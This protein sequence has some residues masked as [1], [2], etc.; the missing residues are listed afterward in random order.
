MT[1]EDAT[2]I[3]ERAVKGESLTAIEKYA[4]GQALLE[5]SASDDSILTAGVKE[6]AAKAGHYFLNSAAV[7]AVDDPNLSE[8]QKLAFGKQAL[9]DLYEKREQMGEL[10]YWRSFA[11]LVLGPLRA[12][13]AT[14]LQ[15]DREARL[16]A[17]YAKLANLFFKGRGMPKTSLEKVKYLLEGKW[18][19]GVGEA[20]DTVTRANSEYFAL[21]WACYTARAKKIPKDEV[22][23]IVKLFLEQI[24][25][26]AGRFM[27]ATLGGVK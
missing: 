11:V 9:I 21:A 16:E 26:K 13:L 7:A 3:L 4:L 15:E 8:R 12:G 19:E 14:R 2:N 20:S 27:L 18:A 23:A 22:P 17:E 24:P 1:A 5:V 10:E 25:N 6:R